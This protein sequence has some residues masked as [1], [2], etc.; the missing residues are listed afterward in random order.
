MTY[1]FDV[2]YHENGATID[3]HYCRE[4]DDKGGCHG[5]RED[6]GLSLEEACGELA[7]WHE[8]QAKAWRDGTHRIAQQFKEQSPDQPKPIRAANHP[9]GGQSDG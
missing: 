7:D 4:W 5:T 3:Y 1:R 9:V 2:I 8:Y 6:H